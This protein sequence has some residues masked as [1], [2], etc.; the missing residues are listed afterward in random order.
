ML[1]KAATVKKFEY[2]PLGKELKARTNI[3]MKHFQKLDDA[4]EFDKIIKIYL[5]KIYLIKIKIIN[6]LFISKQYKNTKFKIIAPTW[7]EFELPDSFYFVS[8]IQGYIEYI[9][10]KHETLTTILPIHVS[11]NRINNRLVFKVKYGYRLNYKRLKQRN[12]LVTQKN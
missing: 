1:E 8:D 12:Y 4:Y 11:I 3:A 5:I 10:K 2:S 6:L 9:I 7:N